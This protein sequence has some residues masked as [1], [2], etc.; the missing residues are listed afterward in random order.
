ML[1]GQREDTL[2]PGCSCFGE[3]PE[4]KRRNV[5]NEKDFSQKLRPWLDRSA[6]GVGEIQ[7][8]RLRA[9]RLR[10]LDQWREPVRLLGLVTVGEGTAQ[11]L[12]YSI[13]QQGLMW[14]PI[15]ILLATLAAKALSPEVD[16]GELDAMLLTGELPID[17]FLDKDF[18]QWL[19]S[20]SGSF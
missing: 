7:A 2:L 13:L 17:A 3:D 18:D 5:R 9:A 4:I 8:T 10:A 19:K 15:V 1:G 16:V 20:A 11:T 14:L 6:D 12:K